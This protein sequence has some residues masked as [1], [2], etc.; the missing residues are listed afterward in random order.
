MIDYAKPKLKLPK[1]YFPDYKLAWSKKIT[2]N[3]ANGPSCDT[4]E[5][6]NIQL[7]METNEVIGHVEADDAL[8]RWFGEWEVGIYD[9][10]AEER[11]YDGVVRIFGEDENGE[12]W[13]VV[14]HNEF[15]DVEEGELPN[16]VTGEEIWDA[17]GGGKAI[18]EL[19]KYIMTNGE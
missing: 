4:I 11:S 7:N 10:Y 6:F 12:Q 1:Q 9:G 15:E 19:Y 5:Y 13:C 3:L 16:G 8:Q 2:L 17:L 18:Y 14:G